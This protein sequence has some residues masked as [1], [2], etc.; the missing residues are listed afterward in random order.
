MPVA[1]R[2]GLY[3][4]AAFFCLLLLILVSDLWR[5]LDHLVYKTFY[6]D[7][8]DQAHLHDDIVVIDIPRGRIDT[9]QGLKAFRE[10]LANLL[11]VIAAGARPRAVILDIWFDRND[12]G[13]GVLTKAINAVRTMEAEGHEKEVDVFRVLNLKELAFNPTRQQV[14]E[15]HSSALYE[16]PHLYAHTIFD[17]GLGVLKYDTQIPLRV[18]GAIEHVPAMPIRVAQA[19][20][21][22]VD[23]E[24]S[25]Y[26]LPIG[27][28][29]QVRERTV[30]FIHRHG[31]TSDGYFAMPRDPKNPDG[32]PEQRPA[33]KLGE[34]IVL[35]GSLLEDMPECTTCTQ[36][37]PELLA[38]SLSDQLAEGSAAR[39]PLDHVGL[40]FA[41]IVALALFT[42]L[43]Y[44][45]L[46]H[47]MRRLQTKPVVL[48]LLSI[49]LGT[50]ALVGLSG[51]ALV[52][53]IVIP[54]SMTLVAIV[55]AGALCASFAYRFLVTGVARGSGKYDVFI[56]YSR[57]HAD[58]VVKNVYE[59]LQ[60][61]TKPDGSRLSIF[62]DR[63]SI[64]LGDH[65]T[66][67]YMWSIVD[68]KVFLA[69]FSEGYY[70]KNHCRNEMDVAYKRSVEK[71]LTILPLVHGAQLPAIYSHMNYVEVDNAPDFMRA[72]E[73]ALVSNESGQSRAAG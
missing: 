63:D 5:G 69:V 11:D 55:L 61:L 24:R 7:E 10:R 71:L 27:P 44:A 65:F 50:A 29:E 33:P 58:W 28:H 15:G 20:G 72:V 14:M 73:R 47:Y 8:S 17:E 35:I 62:F 30:S 45:L 39:R 49:A 19:L 68:S 66:A 36:S 16:E 23:T 22:G 31:A 2:L 1:R 60:T 13:I 38:W 56:S 46:F 54:V 67:K 37:G 70:E 12:D 51:V 6:L 40:I 64:G 41:Q 59:P 34:K 42:V 43:V 21:E 52:L 32:T 4:V 26:V 3:Y 48:A 25:A 18:E 53:D 9:D 57:Q